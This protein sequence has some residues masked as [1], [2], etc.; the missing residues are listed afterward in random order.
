[1]QV[2]LMERKQ[3]EIKEPALFNHPAKRK[4]FGK[5]DSAL[6]TY[7]VVPTQL[8]G[9]SQEQADAEIAADALAELMT[10]SADFEPSST[11]PSTDTSEEGTHSDQD[12][13]VNSEVSVKTNARVRARSDRQ[14]VVAVG[15]KHEQQRQEERLPSIQ[16]FGL[17]VRDAS[18]QDLRLIHKSCSIGV[19]KG[20]LPFTAFDDTIQINKGPL[21]VG[22]KSAQIFPSSHGGSVINL[23]LLVP[24]PH[25]ESLAVCGNAYISAHGHWSAYWVFIVFISQREVEVSLCSVSEMPPAEEIFLSISRTIRPPSTDV[26]GE[27]VPVAQRNVPERTDSKSFLVLFQRDIPMLLHLLEVYQSMVRKDAAAGGVKSSVSSS[28]KKKPSSSSTNSSRS[29]ASSN[30]PAGTP[31]NPQVSSN[32]KIT[33]QT[34]QRPRGGKKKSHYA[35]G[36][37]GGATMMQNGQDGP[38]HPPQQQEQRSHRRS[39]RGGS[40]ARQQVAP[41]ASPEDI[42]ASV[43]GGDA[44]MDDETSRPSSRYAAQARQTHVGIKRQLP[45][46]SKS[47]VASQRTTRRRRAAAAAEA[48]WKMAQ[49]TS[50][51]ETM[52]DDEAYGDDAVEEPEEQD[53]PSSSRSSCRYCG[54]S[55]SCNSSLKRHMRIHTGERPYACQACGKRFRDKSI[56]LTHARIHGGQKPFQCDICQKFFSQK[57]NLTRHMRIHTGERPFKCQFCGKC[58]SQKSHLTLHERTHTGERPFTCNVCNRSFAQK[59]TMVAHQRTHTGAKPFK[60]L[61]CPRHFSQKGNMVSH[62]RLRH[63]KASKKEE[64]EETGTTRRK[65]GRRRR[66]D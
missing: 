19:Q 8:H 63:G 51:A 48:V 6:D 21:L 16:N 33:H 14:P 57:C 2:P 36:G 37:G 30:R 58:F 49:P 66:G 44:M 53:P 25:L 43:A 1:M 18:P 35:S 12:D 11:Q 50:E 60:C 65:G 10:G 29:A 42:L 32:N 28:E 13:R 34:S 9:L 20:K 27:G 24:Q 23:T 39:S 56:L 4:I 26:G 5:M 64:E 40:R 45:S 31:R 3:L 54:K 38:Y 55:F 61:L 59:G 17:E 22:K 47:S 7:H 15:S 46:E 62:M 41:F 52:D